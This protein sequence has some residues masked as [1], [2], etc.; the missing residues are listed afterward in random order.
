MIFG[1]RLQTDGTY[2]FTLVRPSFRPSVR[3]SV[4]PSFRNRLFWEPF[5]EIFWNLVCRCLLVNENS[6]QSLIFGFGLFLA[7]FGQKTAKIDQKLRKLAKSN[8]F[9][10]F[11]WNLVIK[12]FPTKENS[13]TKLSFDFGL[14]CPKDSQNWPKL[15]KIGKI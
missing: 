13:T 6:P 7:F 3:P 14:F 10:Y 12:C 2:R 1:P 9:D 11:F 5:D 4:R 15:T 8:F